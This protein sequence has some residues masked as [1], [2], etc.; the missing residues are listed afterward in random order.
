M[1]TTLSA[2]EIVR[3]VRSGRLTPLEVVEAHIARITKVNPLLNAVA[4]A[5]FTTAREEAHAAAAR[6][7][8]AWGPLHGLP[9]TIKDALDVAGMPATCGLV[10][11]ADRVAPSDATVVA[12]L[13]QAGAIVLATTVTPD[14]CWGQE[15]T[16]PLHG[17]T[18]NPWDPGRTVGGSTGGEAALI[19]ACGSPLGL[20]SDISGSIRLPAAFCGIAGLRPTSGALPE[21][22][23]WPPS[24]GNLA[25][26]NAIGPMARRVEDL[27]LAW[28]VL[29]DG[30]P[31][32]SPPS[33]CGLPLAHWDDDGLLPASR[34]VAAGVAA[35][36]R[37]LQ[38]AGMRPVA[39]APPAR[40]MAGVG[41]GAL[42]GQGERRAIAEGF[43]G[44]MAWSP[45]TELLQV[46]IGR[47]R[48]GR[49][50]LTNWLISHGVPE[51][52]AV[53]RI[54]G[55]RWRAEL[56]A[57]FVALVGAGVAV[58]P[59]FPTTAPRHGWSAVVLHTL[60][61]QQWVNLAGLPALAVPVGFSGRGMPVGVQLVAAPG[62]EA[63]LLA[64]GLAVQQALMPRVVVRSL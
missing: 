15:T 19:A 20:G 32:P 10:S 36:A 2:T 56:Q 39:G 29:R 16:N 43:G 22:G 35:A 3:A 49:A 42:M 54:D 23:F 52:N 48:I 50:S 14:N 41:W 21:D 9:V 47:G 7:R 26:L 1:I 44:G 60:S 17:L 64:A 18:R 5:R 13:R 6:P 62:G 59:V 63:T 34:A 45:Y 61:A 25:L 55:Q 33:L 4:A 46:A 24:V 27:A 53:L 8:S 28:E 31:L 11:R 57:Q 30:G 38:V 37:A 12:R 40:R 58:C 51:L